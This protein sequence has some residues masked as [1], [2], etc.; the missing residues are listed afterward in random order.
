MQE[1]NRLRLRA[2]ALALLLMPF[3]A[4]WVI[5]IEALW[6][7][8]HPT[9]IS[10]FYNVVFTL[11]AV[12]LV[13][14]GLKRWLAPLA[15][16]PGELMVVYTM[17]CLSSAMAGHD[18]IQVLTPILIY[19]FYAASPANG[20]EELF[21]RYLPDWLMV[22]SPDAVKAFYEKGL[23][24]YAQP[25]WS[26]WLVPVLSWTAF[27]TL[28]FFVL[29][30]INVFVRK[31]W[32]ENERL[33]FP[34]VA[35]VET[36]VTRPGEL[37]RR[38]LFWAGFGAAGAITLLNGLNY[39]WPSVPGIPLKLANLYDYVP[40]P[41]WKAIGWTPLNFYPCVLGLSFFM[42][43]DLLFSCWFFY[44]LWKAQAVVI[45]ALGLQPTL[46]RLY[47]NYEAGGGYIAIALIALWAARAH[48]KAV[49][50]QILAAGGGA[51]AVLPAEE[52][53]EPM[54]YRTAACGV[55]VGS[56]ALILFAWVAGLPVW[57]GVAF[58]LIY[59]AFAT[60]I[61]RM[62]AAA[63]PPAHDLHFTGPEN[64]LADTVGSQNLTG[65]TLCVFTLFYG[66]NRA[67]RGQPMAHSIEGFKLA[68]A[69][70]LRQ[71]TMLWMQLLGVGAGTAVAFWAILHITYEKEL[72]G[73]VRYFGREPY[74][75]LDGWLRHPSS[76]SVG[77]PLL[78]AAGAGFV[79]LLE[80]L[81]TRFVGLPFHPIGFAI[82][83]SWSM[84]LIWP[85]V[86]VAWFIKTIVIRYGGSRGFDRASA[87]F[88]GLV[89]GD[90][91]AG[92]AWSIASLFAGRGLYAIWP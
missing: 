59:Y 61:T 17:L 62:R 54:S 82:S 24:L 68:R 1:G 64:I 19:P 2:L 72:G 28:L 71:S 14:T 58:F 16:N 6:Y 10:L 21:F 41:P 38:M 42:P 44:W 36:L 26:A 52:S 46:P 51:G 55:L 56:I 29:L 22:Q 67:Y 85:S 40:G 50:G 73:V 20:W 11:V 91:V 12:L 33:A 89:I 76:S 47:A 3:N 77:V 31:Q 43:V 23:S 83:N 34:V 27:F 25:V 88:A 74:W 45:A 92:G 70:G 35:V 9:T 57:I 37:T 7:A 5:K 75:R 60:A 87:F 49:L 81:R 63:G 65:S 39:L 30:C 69:A 32:M 48:L 84:Q 18:L 86:V 53:G 90:F 4:C 8:G 15:L 79:I 80:W 66:F 13:N 78:L